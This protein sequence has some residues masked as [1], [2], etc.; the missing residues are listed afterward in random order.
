MAELKN[1]EPLQEP[2]SRRDARTRV[3]TVMDGYVLNGLNDERTHE[4][5][6]AQK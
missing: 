3:S 5:H 6:E 1:R 4:E 2:L